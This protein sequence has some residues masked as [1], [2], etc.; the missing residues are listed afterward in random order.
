MTKEELKQEILQVFERQNRKANDVIP[1]R[2][3]LHSFL[4]SLNPKD[5][6]LFEQAANEL[7]DEGKIRYEED[8]FECLRLT[9]DGFANLY[10][11]SKSVYEM[12]EDIMDMFRRGNYREGQ[13]IM[14][15]VFIHSY[16]ETLNPKEK[17]LF[18][19]ACNNLI[20]KHYISY[21]EASPESLRLEQAGYDYIYK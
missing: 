20:D 12:E 14:M 2:Y 10:P 13:N 15:R 21:I 11:N 19:L 5:Q 9:E 8:G 4:T 17:P 16:Y 6:D 3:W 7:I 1:M 18:E